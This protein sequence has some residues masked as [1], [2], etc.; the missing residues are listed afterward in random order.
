MTKVK[1]L[2]K[3]ELTLGKLCIEFMLS[4]VVEYQPQMLGMILLILG[5]DQDIIEIHQDEIIC[6]WLKMKF[7]M[8]ENV[9]GALT[10]PK[11]MTVYS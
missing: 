4:K 11:D 2:I 1:N 3:L 7:I 9:G 8:R 6:V 5:K 10:R